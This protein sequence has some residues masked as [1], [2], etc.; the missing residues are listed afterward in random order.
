MAKET[1]RYKL[2]NDT[3]TFRKV[4]SMRGKTIALDTETKGL[5]FNRKNFL[6]GLC[7]GFSGR[8]AIYAPINHT[9]YKKNIQIDEVREELQAFIDGNKFLFFNYGFDAKALETAGINVDR[10]K[11]LE[12]QSLTFLY[13]PDKKEKSLKAFT[14]EIL[15][16]EVIEFKELGVKDFA[17][18]NPE[19]EMT[20]NYAAADAANTFAL[21][22]DLYPKLKKECPF[23]VKLDCEL[24][25]ALHYL[26]KHKISIDSEYV[27]K[28]ILELNARRDILR[29]SIYKMVGYIFQ[30]TSPIQLSNAL[31][32]IGVDTGT[33]TKR[34]DMSVNK[35]V[36]ATLKHPIGKLITEHASISSFIS[37]MTKLKEIKGGFFN[38]KAFHV[39]SARLAAGSN[40]KEKDSY[41]LQF[42]S[43]N[44]SKG[45][46]Q[47]YRT[48]K[49]SSFDEGIC[50][51]KFIE[52]EDGQ[53]EGQSMGFNHRN[54]LVPREEDRLL[55]EL[56]YKSEE[57]RICSELFKEP[58]MI[59]A[60]R[61]NRDLHKETAIK[62][63]GE[64]NYDSH[65]RKKAKYANFS[66][67]FG[68]SF[69]ALKQADPFI[70]DDDAKNIYNRYW[71]TMKCLKRNQKR[72]IS[73]AYLR[74]GNVYNAYGRPRR[75]KEY[76]SSTEWKLKSFGE[77]C[78]LNTPV[79]GTAADVLRIVLVKLS[80]WIK[81]LPNEDLVYFQNT[82]HDSIVLDIK[83]SYLIQTIKSVKEIMEIKPPGFIMKL[84]VDFQIGDRYGHM[85]DFEFNENQELIPK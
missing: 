9:N 72:S 75:L 6:V 21:F 8:D 70:S 47:M 30:I 4:L 59:N 14:I 33:R 27:T 78:C 37:D 65:H 77:R 17:L 26:T 79:Q 32:A 18:L 60:F 42:N 54:I 1:F 71:E 7:I 35:K 67:I 83:K 64:E 73:R 74:G 52:D 2:I 81:S 45:K 31:H 5:N 82:V 80:K 13:N 49:L 23:S 41:Y 57:L 11:F 63:F 28:L 51:Y 3:E 43:Q 69:R 10:M 62:M 85:F 53:F 68:G 50:G 38:F 12:V 25:K 46:V 44:L 16:R 76:L 15:E 56:D 55:L 40:A 58:V 39:P 66:L 84:P 48:E 36:L 34:G 24:V 61:N 19:E 29:K 20:L 22:T